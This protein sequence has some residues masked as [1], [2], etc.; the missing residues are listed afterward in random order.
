VRDRIGRHAIE[1]TLAVLAALVIAADVVITATHDPTPSAATTT[2]YERAAQAVPAP[3]I[4]TVKPRVALPHRTTPATSRLVTVTVDAGPQ[5]SFLC[6]EDEQGR[7]LFGG[8]LKGGRA[9]RGRRLRFNIG[10]ASTLV[11]VTGKPVTLVGSPTGLEVTRRD[12]ALPLPA[13]LRPC[14]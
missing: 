10:L 14:G 13:T 2:L 11:T 12:G 7:R 4:E 3:P 8:I 1:L 6:V 9:F 5:P